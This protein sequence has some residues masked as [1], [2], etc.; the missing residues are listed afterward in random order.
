MAVEFH[1]V[2][3]WEVSFRMLLH[4]AT[5]CGHAAGHPFFSVCLLPVRLKCFARLFA[6]D[7]VVFIFQTDEFD[8]GL[9]DAS[10][11]VQSPVGGV[12]AVT[13]SALE[14][15]EVVVCAWNLKVQPVAAV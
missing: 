12:A 14:Q 15:G 8:D 7:G 6:E 13:V 9:A 3:Q 10:F 1:P 2:G 4:D 5:E 11:L